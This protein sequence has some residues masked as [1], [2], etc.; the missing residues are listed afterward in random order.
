MFKI[1]NLLSK[2]KTKNKKS[3]HVKLDNSSIIHMASKDKKWINIFRLSAT[4]KEDVDPQ[5]LQTA[6][7]VTIK[8]FPSIAA[9]I[10]RG[11][12]WYYQ[13]EIDS[14]PSIVKDDNCFLQYMSDEDLSECAFRVLYSEK[15]IMVECFHALTDG[16]GG[17][18]F[19]KSLIAEYLN[20]KYNLSISST[21]GVL[22]REEKPLQDEI[23]DEYFEIQSQVRSRSRSR[24]RIKNKPVYQISGEKDHKLNI[25]T[26]I[27]HLD[28]I[29][30]L[31]KDLNVSL[32]VLITSLVMYTLIDIQKKEVKARKQRPI[33]IFLPVDLRNFF[34]SKT[35]RN[36][37]YYA[38]PEIDPRDGNCTLREIVNSVKHQLGEQL[39]EDNLRARVTY[40]VQLERKLI[41]R[42]LPLFLKR[43][44]MK[45]IFSLNE[46]S[47]CMTISNLG[48][49]TAPKE[50][51]PYIERFEGIL[52]PRKKSPYN[53]GITSYG[54][55]LYIN[56]IRNTKQPAL[57][58]GFFELL[59]N[60]NLN[61][62]IETGV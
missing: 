14:A 31:S 37:V 10:H 53:C 50:M 29:K 30:K 46:K 42:V 13:S 58:R 34:P 25:T 41:V 2:E 28:E 11:M 27:I 45:S 47:T 44:L 43:L 33:K 9:R 4:L 39:T 7:N 52:S 36:F 61:F 24:S 8:R 59:E 38:A 54:D 40:N 23:I 1:M 48:I 5:I 17:M 16:N 32:T 57:E 21:D 49:I 56:F 3:T 22:N 20:Q 6:L 55:K 62:T 51:E 35:L 26:S 18:K 12:F 19:L 60:L 15:C